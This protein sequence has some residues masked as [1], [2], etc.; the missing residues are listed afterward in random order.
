MPLTAGAPVI[1][2]RVVEHRGL[3]TLVG[4]KADPVPAEGFRRED[5]EPDSLDPAGCSVK[6]AIDDL[7]PYSHGLEDLAPLYPWR[8]EM[9]ILAMTLS[10]PFATPFR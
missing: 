8:V 1:F 5:V 9:P 10:I 6:A 2:A 4:G 7:V 3:D